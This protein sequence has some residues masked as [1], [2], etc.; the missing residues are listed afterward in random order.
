MPGLR[1]SVIRI[2]VCAALVLLAGV[3]R[4][5]AAGCSVSTSPLV[6]GTYNVFSATPVDSTATVSYR[7]NGNADG[8]LVAIT[9]GQSP[10]FLPR[11]LGKGTERLSYNLF[12]DAARTSVWGDFTGGTSALNDLN[13]PNN[14]EVDVTIFGRIPPGQDISAGSYADTVTVVV[15]F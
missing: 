15:L 7:C 10:T 3:S 13:P 1:S 2:A 11:Q 6:F 12:R 5:E 4:T 9:K 8:V 14:K